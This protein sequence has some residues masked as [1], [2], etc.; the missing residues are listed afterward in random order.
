[1]INSPKI[2]TAENEKMSTSNSDKYSSE[3]GPLLITQD[4]N[5]H[6]VKRSYWDL[7]IFKAACN[8]NDTN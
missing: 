7:S 5:I 8:W 3:N 1:M 4:F 2:L 6:V